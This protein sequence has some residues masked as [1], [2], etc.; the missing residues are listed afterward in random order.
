MPNGCMCCRVRGDLVDA[1]KRLIV[2]SNN[3][4]ADEDGGPSP[5]LVPDGDKD[6]TTIDEVGVVAAGETADKRPA[7]DASSGSD[8][9]SQNTAAAAATTTAESQAQEVGAEADAATKLDGIILE[10]SGLDELAP[11]LQVRVLT[12]TIDTYRMVLA[13]DKADL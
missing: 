12:C 11:V 6:G 8:G 10:C 2:S 13:A 5:S 9:P 3:A 7:R 1:L 4:S